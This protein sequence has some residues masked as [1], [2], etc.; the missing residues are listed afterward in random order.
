MSVYVSFTIVNLWGIPY[1]SSNLP[2]PFLQSSMNEKDHE[3]A[4]DSELQK[5]RKINLKNSQNKLF[6]W[7]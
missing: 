3:L 2:I 6:S 1:R 7:F 5:S 4:R